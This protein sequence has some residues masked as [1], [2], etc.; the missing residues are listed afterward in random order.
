MI[1]SITE[2]VREKIKSRAEVGA[3]KYGCTMDREDLTELAWI[4]H[5]Q[6]EMLD[7]A[8]YLEKLIQAKEQQLRMMAIKL[9]AAEPPEHGDCCDCG[10][11]LLKKE[12]T[13][14]RGLVLKC[15][16]CGHEVAN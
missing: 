5:A 14:A 15:D 3:K 9:K 8:V 12:K 11:V 16:N 1:D 10:G 2:A 7:G 6:L 4:K 13:D